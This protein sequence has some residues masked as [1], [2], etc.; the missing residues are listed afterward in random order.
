MSWWG[1]GFDFFFFLSCP[2]DG[3]VGY[4]ARIENLPLTIKSAGKVTGF[5]TRRWDKIEVLDQS[6]QHYLTK[7]RGLTLEAGRC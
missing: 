3:W 7:W 1:S 5:W 6:W 2:G 4:A